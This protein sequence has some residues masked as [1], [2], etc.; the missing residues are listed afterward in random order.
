MNDLLK[1]GDRVKHE[2]R[3]DWG[4]GEVLNDQSGDRVRVIFEDVGVKTFDLRIAIFKKVAER[5]PNQITF[6]PW[7]SKH[8]RPARKAG[9]QESSSLI[10]FSRAVEIFLRQFPRGF[11]DPKY[12][13]G[14]ASEREY[15]LV[16]HQLT[17]E[18]LSIHELQALMQVGNY[19]EIC[20]R[21]KRI[22]SKTN[23]IHHYEKM[24]LADALSTEGRR[25]LF[26]QEL[27]KL[28][29]GEGAMQSRFERYTKMLYDIGAAKW[30][31]ATYFLFLANPETQIFVKPEVTKHAAKILGIDIDYR[32]EVNWPTYNR[33]IRLAEE[34]KHKLSEERKEELVPRDMI[35]VQSFIWVIGP[36]YFV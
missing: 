9:K 29:Y 31:I 4:L 21:A 3:T 35:D 23:L 27:S 14:T 16:A 25:Q 22:I 19:A 34:L 36:G 6:P 32:P 26:A 24:W 33:V 2:S 13:S 12:T 28:L 8:L 17:L 11:Q 5:K 7:L 30:T 15:K 10:S 20:D 1:R 18:L